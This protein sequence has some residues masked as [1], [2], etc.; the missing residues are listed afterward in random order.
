MVPGGGG[1]TGAGPVRALAEGAHMS[2]ER[3]DCC[4]KDGKASDSK[5]VWESA[6]FFTCLCR[7]VCGILR[8]EATN[9]KL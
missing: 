1:S 4:N 2:G 8:P 3:R 9:E 6:G 7:V 5:L